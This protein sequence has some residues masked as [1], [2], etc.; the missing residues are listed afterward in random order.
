[1]IKLAA[2]LILILVVYAIGVTLLPAFLRHRRA[3]RHVHD[4]K[5][6]R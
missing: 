6:R 1:M 3:R 2:G 4:K 5:R